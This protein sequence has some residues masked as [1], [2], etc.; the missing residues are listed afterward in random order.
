MISQHRH[1]I[2][3][4]T[5]ELSSKMYCGVNL[6]VI[7][8]VLLKISILDMSLKLKT[9]YYGRIAVTRA[10]YSIPV[11]QITDSNT[12]ECMTFW[13]KGLMLCVMFP[14]DIINDKKKFYHLHEQRHIV[15]YRPKVWKIL[16]TWHIVG[17]LSVLLMGTNH[18]RYYI[19]VYLQNSDC[20]DRCKLENLYL[21]SVLFI[22]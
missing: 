13:H 18:F 20:Q 7:L 8:Q 15:H 10:T 6:R 2:N 14:S 22:T 16:L 17:L 12:R 21:Y 11:F 9:S 4:Q 1:Q 3:V 19:H 5:V